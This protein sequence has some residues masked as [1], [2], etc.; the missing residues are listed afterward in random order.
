MSPY[1]RWQELKAKGPTLAEIEAIDQAT[2]W[3][4]VEPDWWLEMMGVARELRRSQ[5]G[6]G[7]KE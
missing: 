4:E 6:H 1:Q 3:G 5:P 7:S 2:P